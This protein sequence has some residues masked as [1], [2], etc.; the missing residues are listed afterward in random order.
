MSDLYGTSLHLGDTPP[1]RYKQYCCR[2]KAT[3]CDIQVFLQRACA[4]GAKRSAEGLGSPK[5]SNQPNFAKTG[6]GY[7]EQER[8]DRQPSA[9]AIDFISCRKRCAFKQLAV[10]RKADPAILSVKRSLP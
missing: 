4:F 7:Q 10:R 8:I 3:V 1:E 6:F 5:H 2:L 9:G